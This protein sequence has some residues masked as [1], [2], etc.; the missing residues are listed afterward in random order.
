MTKSKDIIFLKLHHEY[1]LLEHNLLDQLK[2]KLV[3]QYADL[4]LV[5][6]RIDKLVYEL[7]LSIKS[8][9]HSVISVI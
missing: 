6:R 5:K 9:I 1:H 4:F 3:N 8:K 2:T 7:D